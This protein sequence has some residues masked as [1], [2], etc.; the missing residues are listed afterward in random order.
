MLIIPGEGEVHGTDPATGERYC[1]RCGRRLPQEGGSSSCV[2]AEITPRPK[3]EQFWATTPF[4]LGSL[5]LATALGL[6]EMWA[7][8]SSIFLGSLAVGFGAFGLRRDRGSFALCGLVLG[9]IAVTFM[10]VVLGVAI[11]AG[12]L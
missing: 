6:H 12:D 8:L 10:L 7:F 5:A 11:G 9:A 2:P 4:V 3:G 1:P